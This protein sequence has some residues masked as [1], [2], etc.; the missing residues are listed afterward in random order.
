VNVT[1]TKVYEWKESN[2]LET[3]IQISRQRQF[4]VTECHGQNLPQKPLSKCM[5]RGDGGFQQGGPKGQPTPLACL[6]QMHMH[7]RC[8]KCHWAT[9]GCK[10]VP[11]CLAK[12]KN[13]QLGPLHGPIKGL[14]EAITGFYQL[15]KG[16]QEGLVNSS[17]DIDSSTDESRA[18]RAK[19]VWCAVH[20]TRRT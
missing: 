20:L 10:K 16:L 13:V 4:P 8:H 7:G 15:L 17:N 2:R 3:G 5:S 19:H 18:E 1:S 14:Q 11:V 6:R 12:D 9:G